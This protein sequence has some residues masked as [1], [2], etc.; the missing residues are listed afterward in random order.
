MIKW[1]QETCFDVAKMFNSKGEFQK[2]NKTAYE[3]ARRNGWLDDYKWFKSLM[4][5]SSVKNLS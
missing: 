3:T 4:K 5:K 2:G 1:N